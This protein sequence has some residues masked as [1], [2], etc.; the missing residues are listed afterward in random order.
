LLLRNSTTP[1]LSLAQSDSPVTGSPHAVALAREPEAVGHVAG[2]LE[3]A[4]DGFQRPV[5]GPVE[6]GVVGIG[7]QAIRTS[8]EK[9]SLTVGAC[10]EE[11]GEQIL[12]RSK[13]ASAGPVSFAA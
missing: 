1:G 4:A 2:G 13:G 3:G 11:A 10:T 7:T 6:M 5:E 8:S 9:V 12:P